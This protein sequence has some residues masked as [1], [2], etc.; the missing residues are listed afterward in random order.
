VAR[1]SAIA[2][3]LLLIVGVSSFVVVQLTTSSWSQEQ[4][5]NVIELIAEPKSCGAVGSSGTIT[6]EPQLN[7]F[8]SENWMKMAGWIVER[9][10]AKKDAWPNKNT[11]WQTWKGVTSFLGTSWHGNLKVSLKL[12]GRGEILLDAGNANSQGFVRYL[13]NGE[14]RKLVM[15]GNK[16]AKASL[17]FDNDSTL[18]LREEDNGVLQI[19]SIHFACGPAAPKRYEY[20]IRMNGT[21]WQAVKP[22]TWDCNTCAVDVKDA[23]ARGNNPITEPVNGGYAIHPSAM[24]TCASACR[25][26]GGG[27]CTGFAFP[28]KGTQCYIMST[29]CKNRLRSIPRMCELRYP[30]VESEEN[31]AWVLYTRSNGQELS[32]TV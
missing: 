12:R 4:N 5:N 14:T 15:A 24:I 22:S 13:I 27:T 19:N 25:E 32:S 1:L 7:S 30:W 8:V 31:V 18:E 29:N 28:I 26:L 17:S 20:R 10:S 11:R 2:V 6:T 3:A 21:T 16:H 23:V 9:S